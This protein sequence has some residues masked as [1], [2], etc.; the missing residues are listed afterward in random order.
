MKTYRMTGRPAEPID[1]L[2]GHTIGDEFPADLDSETERNLVGAGV[3]AVL[4]ET[5]EPETEPEPEEEEE[6]EPEPE[7]EPE[8]VPAAKAKAVKTDE[9]KAK[10]AA[11][12]NRASGT[13]RSRG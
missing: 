5:P 7:E 13:V 3:L 6:P 1:L 4:D 2:I 8:P 9:P 11:K 12:R 10:Q